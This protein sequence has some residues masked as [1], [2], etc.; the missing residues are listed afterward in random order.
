MKQR[1]VLEICAGGGG[2]AIGLEAAGFRHV[3]AI[4]NDHDA[5][6]TLRNNLAGSGILETDVKNIRGSDFPRV[7]LLAGGVPCPPFSIAGKQLGSSDE[8]DLFPEALRLVKELEP[9]AVLLENVKGLASQKFAPYLGQIAGRLQSMQYQVFF[10][11]LNAADFGVPQL[12]PRFVLVALKD[13]YAG[14]FAWPQVQPRQSTVAEAIHDLMGANGW[15]GMDQWRRK[16]DRIAPTL[17]GGSKKHGGP[18]LGPT[19]AKRQW[20]QL[21]IDGRGIAAE[22]P[23][24]DFPADGFP[25][26]TLPMVARI[27]GFPDTWKFAGNKTSIYRQIGNAFPP[28]VAAA[29]GRCIQNALDRKPLRATPGTGLPLEPEN[30]EPAFCAGISGPRFSPSARFPVVSAV[31]PENG[32]CQGLAP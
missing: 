4:D 5:C 23:G 15:P 3:C 9:D 32:R 7:D 12:R 19:R 18:D 8:R 17:V 27:Q 6:E 22:A 29:V 31:P 14:Y 24:R 16:A 21:G 1:S 13:E 2:Q 10:R 28:P 25:R 20:A 11:I 30:D 26:L